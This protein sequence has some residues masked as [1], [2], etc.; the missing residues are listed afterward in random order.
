MSKHPEVSA[1]GA[2][3]MRA[4]HDAISIKRAVAHIPLTEEAAL[5]GHD[6]PRNLAVDCQ[7]LY[8]SNKY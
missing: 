2:Y 4:C 6:H 7:K 5:W 3:D 1:D 8:G